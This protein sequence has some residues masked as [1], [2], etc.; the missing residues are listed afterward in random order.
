MYNEAQEK[1]PES[2]VSTIHIIQRNLIN[3]PEDDVSTIN[4]VKRNI[5]HQLEDGVTMVKNVQFTTIN[6]PHEDM[7]YVE[8]PPVLNR[9]AINR[10]E[11]FVWNKADILQSKSIRTHERTLTTDNDIGIK[12]GK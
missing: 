4:I 1:Q 5:G 7:E 3:Q 10:R 9:K 12:S 2:G 6:E 11:L 8:T